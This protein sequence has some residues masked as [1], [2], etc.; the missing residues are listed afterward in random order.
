[1]RRFFTYLES[2]HEIT[3]LN[4]IKS[5]IINAYVAYLTNLGRTETY[6][7]S[8]LKG[9]RAFFKYCVEEEYIA[10]TPMKKVHFQKERKP[11]ILTFS[12]SEVQKM[13]RY[14]SGPRYLDV[15]NKLI[16][17][18]LFD[19]GIRN[20]ELCNL[21]I[22]DIRETYIL[23]RGKG[24]KDRV[25]PISP[26]LS[27]Q[28]IKYDRVR[29]FYIKDKFAYQTEYLLLSQKGKQLTI[30]TIE[31]IVAES[32]IG[33]KVNSA[34]RCSPHTCRHYFAQSQLRNGCDLYTLS[35][36]LGHSNLNITK[37][38]LQSINHEYFLELARTTSPLMNL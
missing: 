13:V 10:D 8:I 16:M 30:A 37:I 18:I 7:N 25:V 9:F 29:D 23:I 24:K 2:E 22:T 20:F 26:I 17:M 6:I 35:K 21:K 3:E 28:L 38:Y 33:C 32:G 34:I 11:L 31:R 27:K 15:R 12:D 36:L 5:P 1:M 19:T 4:Y 14:F